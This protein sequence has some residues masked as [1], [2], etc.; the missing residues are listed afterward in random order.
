MG[1]ILQIIPA[2]GVLGGLIGLYGLYLYY[3]WVA[4]TLALSEV[5]IPQDVQV[6]VNAPSW[7]NSL[8]RLYS[9][10]ALPV[11]VIGSAVFFIIVVPCFLLGFSYRWFEGGPKGERSQNETE[12]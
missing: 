3:I 9:T 11:L 8:F 6:M 2:L 1:G 7:L 10:F 5:I 4:P 12:L